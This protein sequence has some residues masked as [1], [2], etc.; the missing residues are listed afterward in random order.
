MISLDELL[1]HDDHIEVDLL[2]QSVNDWRDEVHDLDEFYAVLLSELG[3][4]PTRENIEHYLSRVNHLSKSWEVESLTSL[5]ELFTH[6][7]DESD[8]YNIF[9]MISEKYK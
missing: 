7:K 2:L 8:L 4:K 9:Q 6:F 5:I 3:N 1:K